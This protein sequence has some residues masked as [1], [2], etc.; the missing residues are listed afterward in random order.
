MGPWGPRV[1]CK[2]PTGGRDL[3]QTPDLTEE[4]DNLQA[5][6]VVVVV[7]VAPERSGPNA[8]DRGLGKLRLAERIDLAERH[9]AAI[10]A[11]AVLD[12][13]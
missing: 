7:G 2:R 12:R 8:T 3:S 5:G 11:R 9:R 10:A 13:A 6:P 1:G 4:V